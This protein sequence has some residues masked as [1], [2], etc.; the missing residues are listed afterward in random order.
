MK[1]YVTSFI[2]ET[3]LYLLKLEEVCTHFGKTLEMSSYSSKNFETVGYKHSQRY[4]VNI[5]PVVVSVVRQALETSVGQK[6]SGY[7]EFSGIMSRL[8]MWV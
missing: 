4:W 6:G 3:E 2:L 8:C 7:P 5:K 1:L